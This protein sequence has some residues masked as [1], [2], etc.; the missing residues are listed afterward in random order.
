AGDFFPTEITGL[1]IGG[2]VRRLHLLH[3][4]MFADKDGTP[5]AKIVFHYADGTEE[6]VRLGYGVHVRAWVTPR[7][8][9]H[10]T[11]FDPNSQV[12]WADTD[13][14]RGNGTRLFQTAL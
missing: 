11:L 1:K 4:T 6:S 12:A 10:S 8:E 13:E 14:M 7:L 3:G 9:K 2:P 5:V